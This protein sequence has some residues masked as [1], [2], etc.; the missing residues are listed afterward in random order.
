MYVYVHV[1]V[2]VYAHVRVHVSH[3]TVSMAAGLVTLL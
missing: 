1:H 3:N 2:H